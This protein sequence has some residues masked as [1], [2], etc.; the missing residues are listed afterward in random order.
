MNEKLKT[1]KDLSGMEIILG[2]GLSTRRLAIQTALGVGY[3]LAASPLIAQTAIRTPSMGLDTAEVM[4]DR[5]GFKFPVF[6][7]KPSN[8]Q[9]LPVVLVVSE[10][11]GVHEYIAD[12]ARRF[13]QAG[14]C[15]IAP[16]LFARQGDPSEYAQLSKLQSEVI[17]KV[18]DHQVLADLDA[19]LLWA[20]HQGFDTDRLAINGF[21]WGGRIAWLYAAHQGKLKAAAA[22]YGRLQGNQTS[23]TPEHPLDLKHG[24]RAP[25]LGLYGDKDLSI[26]LESIQ[27]M[28][29]KLQIWAR[30]GDKTAQSSR[31]VIY[32]GVGHAFHA[33][34]RSSYDQGAAT[35]AWQ[36]TLAWFK[37]RLSA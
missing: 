9:D 18:P 34:Y 6:V 8:K 29:E 35:D 25:V 24:L 33:D 17:D 13:A 1:S 16:E 32:P 27:R 30:E 37:L 7:A 31:F 4:I 22:W 15:A 14:Y 26:A 5:E 3:A 36:Q 23:N 20:K 12:V 21:C 10:I 2:P 28:Q 11:F 19:C